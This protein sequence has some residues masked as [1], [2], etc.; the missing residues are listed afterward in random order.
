MFSSSA[1]IGVQAPTGIVAIL[2]PAPPGRST[3]DGMITFQE[4]GHF[5]PIALLKRK[6]RVK[7]SCTSFARTA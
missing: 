2:I 3:T 4:G 6:V 7:L 1:S 5:F